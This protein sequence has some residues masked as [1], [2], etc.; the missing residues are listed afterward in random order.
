MAILPPDPCP[1]QPWWRRV[2]STLLQLVA[3]PG[4]EGTLKIVLLALEITVLYVGVVF[5][6]HHLA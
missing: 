6:M 2:L 4:W 5:A 1:H 3:A